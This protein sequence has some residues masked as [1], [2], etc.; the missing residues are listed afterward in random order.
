MLKQQ[1]AGAIYIAS[2][3]IPFL[4]ITATFVALAYTY[5]YDLPFCH[6]DESFELVKLGCSFMP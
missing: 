4:M 6:M 1:V 5:G 2:Q 3:T